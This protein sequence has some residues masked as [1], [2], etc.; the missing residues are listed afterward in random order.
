MLTGKLVRESEL[1][2]RDPV[3]FLRRLVTPRRAG[4]AHAS[5]TRCASG[6]ASS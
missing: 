3:S 2:A 6:G 4:R 1:E 5:V